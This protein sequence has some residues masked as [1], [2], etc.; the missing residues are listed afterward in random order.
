MLFRSGLVSFGRI[1]V[2]MLIGF[3]CAG[4]IVGV[5]GS[6]LSMGK[7]LKDEGGTSDE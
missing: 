7:Y 4:V 5:F 3:L 6:A 2:T 1:W